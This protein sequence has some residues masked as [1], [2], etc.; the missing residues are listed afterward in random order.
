MTPSASWHRLSE[1]DAEARTAVCAQCGPTP[2]RLG[3]RSRG[4][5]CGTK[6]EA[7]KAAY[8]A[9]KHGVDR[10]GLGSACAICGA[11]EDLVVDHDHACCPGQRGC[12]NC[13]RGR[14]CRSCNLALGYFKDDVARIRRA[15]EYLER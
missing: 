7:D 2:I 4:P 5:E 3:R 8:L 1:V 12:S 10:E 15:L 11:T 14:L 13:V 6:R 9:R